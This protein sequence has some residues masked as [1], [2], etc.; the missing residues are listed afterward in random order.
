[1]EKYLRKL[2]KSNKFQCIFRQAKDY[3]FKIFDNNQDLSKIQMVFLHWLQTY[4]NLYHDLIIGEE[5]LT[6]EVIADDLRT[7]AY[8]F[9]KE[10]KLKD[11]NLQKHTVKENFTGIPSVIFKQ[12][13][14]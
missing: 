8:L 10:R 7:E 1:M 5:F 14:K 4:Q 2:A 6:E 9:Y 13:R 3:H 11:K 12:K